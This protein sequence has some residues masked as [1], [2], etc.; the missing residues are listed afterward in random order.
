MSDTKAE[1]IEAAASAVVDALDVS[2]ESLVPG[3]GPLAWDEVNDLAKNKVRIALA[4]AYDLWE[5]QWTA[6]LAAAGQPKLG[7]RPIR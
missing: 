3:N 4:A 1:H 2:A 7:F 5:K 6:D